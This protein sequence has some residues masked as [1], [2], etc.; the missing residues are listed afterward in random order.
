MKRHLLFDILIIGAGPAGIVAAIHAAAGGRSLKIGLID[1]KKEPG[2][3]V[4]CGEAVG[5]KGFSD[6]LSIDK[7]WIKSTVVKAKLVSPSGIVITLPGDFDNYIIDRGKMEKDLVEQAIARGVAF[8]SGA[9]IVSLR[10]NGSGRY[11]CQASSGEK[12]EAYCIILAD[13]IES[14]TARELGW[15]TFLAPSD[16]ISCAFARVEHKKIERDTCTFHVG[17]SVAPG[18]YAWVFPRGEKETN[19]GLGVLGSM[20]RPGLPKE[21]LLGFIGRRFPGSKISHL[22]CGGVPMGPWLKPLVKDGA[23]IVGDAARQVNCATGAGIAYS[24][25]SGK[26]AGAAA[27]AAFKEAKPGAHCNFDVLKKYEKDWAAYYGKQQRRSYSLK[28]TMVGFSD[29]FLDDVA[30]SLK[31]TD[32]HKLKV[33]RV[34][35]K[36]FSKHPMQLLKVLKLFS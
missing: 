3:P 10:R 20:S 32:P 27:A 1:R 6:F 2:V 5:L 31:K 4:R 33:S 17:R 25:F 35:L 22:H 21:L 15:K 11:E 34:F 9:T 7:T 14:K 19:V 29:A 12:F 8:I 18:G 28:E 26:A 23:M 13:G 36:A 30:K 24:F 16:I